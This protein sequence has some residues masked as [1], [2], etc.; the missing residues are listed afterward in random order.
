MEHIQQAKAWKSQ[1]LP[2]EPPETVSSYPALP[3]AGQSKVRL[4][5]T[6]KVG[7]KCDP[8]VPW[9][10]HD[11]RSNENPESCLRLM[12]SSTSGLVR[13]LRDGQDLHLVRKTCAT[14]VELIGATSL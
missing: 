11:P 9:H 4:L 10:K 7:S 14:P 3:D 12:C 13:A 5:A 1:P 2:E 6:P 8:Y